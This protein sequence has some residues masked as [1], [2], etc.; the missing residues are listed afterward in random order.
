MGLW[1]LAVEYR[2]DRAQSLQLTAVL[3]SALTPELLNDPDPHICLLTLWGSSSPTITLPCQ[4][5][6]GSLALQA[7]DSMPICLQVMGE[8]IQ[9]RNP[10]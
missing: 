10:C 5:N 8:G 7:P 2:R 4:T 6:L 9:T 1:A 3:T